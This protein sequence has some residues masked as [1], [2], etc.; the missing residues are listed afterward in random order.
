MIKVVLLGFGNLGYHLAK[1]FQRSKNVNLIQIYC[2]SSVS[3]RSFN[4]IHDLS[5]ITSADVY[6]IA[7]SDDEIATFSKQLN[8]NNKLVVHTSGSVNI[9]ELSSANFRGVFYPLQTF[10]KDKDVDFKKIPIC[11]EA[12]RSKDLDVLNKLASS[13]ADNVYHLNS[14]QRKQLHLAAVFINNFVNHLYFIGEEICKQH[15]IPFEILYPLI[16]E[17]SQKGISLSPFLAQTGPA[18]RN[19]LTTIKK[20][21]EM[22]PLPYQKIYE[23]L[24]SSLTNTYNNN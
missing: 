17:T 24:T 2:R 19:D 13:I 20:Q 12:E 3:N 6:I 11:I 8:F 10:S 5:K 7:I 14:E 18:K 9:D 21:L 23:I 15:E 22:L 4:F 1:A 16:T